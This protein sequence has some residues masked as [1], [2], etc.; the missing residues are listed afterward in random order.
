MYL[1]FEV[2]KWFLILVVYNIWIVDNLEKWI[3]FLLVYFYGVCLYDFWLMYFNKFYK[4]IL[5][6]IFVNNILN[7]SF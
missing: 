5:E 4:L 3:N 1:Y 6:F 2:F 7:W